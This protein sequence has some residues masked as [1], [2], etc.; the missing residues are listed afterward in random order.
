M[1]RRITIA[2][3]GRQIGPPFD[4]PAHKLI[5]TIVESQRGLLERSAPRIDVAIVEDGLERFDIAL[6][7]QILEILWQ[8]LSFGLGHGLAPDRWWPHPSDGRILYRFPTIGF[9]S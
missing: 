7:Q 9:S 4:Q 5:R 2:V 3:A 1:Q 6:R 8:C